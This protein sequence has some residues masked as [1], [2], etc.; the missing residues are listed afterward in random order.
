[1]IA[2]TLSL[3]GEELRLRPLVQEDALRVYELA[4]NWNI[5]SMLARMPYPYTQGSAE[6]WISGHIARRAS[7]DSWPL[8]IE[9]N[10]ELVGTIGLSRQGDDTYELGYWVGEPYW[11]Q[12]I[13]TRAARVLVKFAFDI[14]GASRLTAGHFTENPASGRILTNIGFQKTGEESRFCLARGKN[15]DCIE[16]EL[17]ASK[18]F[19]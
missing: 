2:E 19:P 1:M 5:A 17:Y 10:S 8:A 3:N 6:E 13:A 9:V 12:G 11:G 18:V 16:F 14:L 4:N 15:V 7:G